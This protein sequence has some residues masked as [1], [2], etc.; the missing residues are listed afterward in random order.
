MAQVV[1]MMAHQLA[2]EARAADPTH[3]TAPSES[4]PTPPPEVTGQT[5]DDA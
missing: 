3:R 4:P 5:G 1:L 2:E